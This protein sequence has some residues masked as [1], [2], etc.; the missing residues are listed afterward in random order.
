MGKKAVAILG[1]E[2]EEA[3][4]KKAAVK[5][6]QKKLRKGE[7]PKPEEVNVEEVLSGAPPAPEEKK[8]IKK[9]RVRSKNYQSLKS[10]VDVTRTYSLS[11]GIKLLREVSYAKFDPSVELHLSLKDKGVSK[12]VEMPHSTGKVKRISIANEETLAKIEKGQID[13]DVLL[14]SADQMPKI[15][16]FAKVLGPKGLMPNPKTGTVVPNPEKTA[17]EMSGKNSLYLKT[18]KDAPLI[19]TTV[20]KLSM[21]DKDLTDN[22]SAVTGA[23]SG[24][25]IKIVLKSSMSPAIKL[26]L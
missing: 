26:S 4:K 21:S 10:K 9:V 5:R 19:H 25:T 14:A 7:G 20:G 1:T 6:E 18:E 17:K 13:F 24:K 15:V 11:D 23:L 22:I 8:S 12:D 3:A 2:D 16:K